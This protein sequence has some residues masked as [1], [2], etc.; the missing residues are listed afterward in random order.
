MLPRYFGSVLYTLIL[1]RSL[2][3]FFNILGLT[4]RSSAT[5]SYSSFS[6]NIRCRS[7]PANLYGRHA[8]SM[9]YMQHI[10]NHVGWLGSYEHHC[11]VCRL[12]SSCNHRSIG[13]T[14]QKRGRYFSHKYRGGTHCILTWQQSF[15]WHLVLILDALTEFGPLIIICWF[16]KPLNIGRRVK[17]IVAIAFATRIP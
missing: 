14:L 11:L 8:S 4:R 10:H 15:R 17:M 16:L 2:L 9:G 5:R 3:T 13:W 7:H 6:Q 1:H 12:S